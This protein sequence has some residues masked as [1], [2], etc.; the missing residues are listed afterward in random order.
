MSSRGNLRWIEGFCTQ[1]GNPYQAAGVAGDIAIQLI[2]PLAGHSWSQQSLAAALPGD[3][4]PAVGDALERELFVE[5][6]VV[7]TIVKVSPV[8]GLGAATAAEWVLRSGFIVLPSDH[9]LGVPLVS[10]NGLNKQDL[11]VAWIHTEQHMAR[12]YFDPTTAELYAPTS[13][14]YAHIKHSISISRR[15]NTEDLLVF[16]VDAFQWNGADLENAYFSMHGY[17]R[18][19]V[20]DA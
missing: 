16:I 8:P 11:E 19:L 2:L 13:G 14:I 18:V 15:L 6:I 5:R 7:D 17:C 3:L 1:P 12:E 10:L 4:A 9:N 20:R